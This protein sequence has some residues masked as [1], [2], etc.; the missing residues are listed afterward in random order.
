MEAMWNWANDAGLI[1]V[2]IAV[3]HPMLCLA[4]HGRQSHSIMGELCARS[5]EYDRDI[6][7][8]NGGNFF[9]PLP[10]LANWQ[11]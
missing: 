1:L 8:R 9:C 10:D 6:S 2:A 5:N 4:W 11:N 3:I 7:D